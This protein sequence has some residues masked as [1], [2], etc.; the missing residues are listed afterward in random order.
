[1]N[2]NQE[3]DLFGDGGGPKSSFAEAFYKAGNGL[4]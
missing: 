2:N 3:E 4:D 1:M